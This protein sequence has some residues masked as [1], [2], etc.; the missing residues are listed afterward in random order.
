MT[1]LNLK[2]AFNG[3]TKMLYKGVIAQKFPFDFYNPK[4]NSSPLGDNN[5]L[6]DAIAYVR[7]SKIIPFSGQVHGYFFRHFFFFF[8]SS[9]YHHSH[10]S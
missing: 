8:K 10:D 7:A 2:D 4:V 3:L 6:T 5:G 9:K 1:N